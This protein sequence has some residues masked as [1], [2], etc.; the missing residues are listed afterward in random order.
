MLPAR[1]QYNLLRAARAQ[2]NIS[3]CQKRR[4]REN[5]KTHTDEFQGK[6]FTMFAREKPREQ[7]RA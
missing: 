5:G 1:F 6:L 7:N 3:L 4:K 2:A